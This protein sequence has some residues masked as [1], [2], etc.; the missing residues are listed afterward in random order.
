MAQSIADAFDAL[1]CADPAAAVASTPVGARDRAAL[2]AAAVDVERLLATVPEGARVG[3]CVRDGFLLLAA[4]LAVLRTRRCA[5]LLDAADPRA[6]HMALAGRLGAAAVLCD[7]DGLRLLPADGRA[8][9]G[10]LRAIK[11]TSGSTGEPR[12]IGVGER[13]LI[14]DATQLERTMGIGDDDRVL[15]AV[16][17]TFSY[18]VGNLLV[19]ALLRGRAL[20]LPDASSPIGLLRALRDGRPTVLPAVPALLRALLRGGFTPPESLRLVLSAGA[21]LPVDVARAWRERFALPVHAFYGSTE[22]GGICYDRRGD[23]AERGLVGAPVDGV[24]VSL[25]ADGRVL[26][27]SAAVGYALGDGGHAR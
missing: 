25:R 5:V 2:H 23:A 8:E 15:A 27:R 21:Q 17:M 6:P 3:L 22:S 14:A 16:P 19:P 13:E 11:L 12:A 7:R 24:D 20:V 18:G 26:V 9:A 10:R 4:F 1:R